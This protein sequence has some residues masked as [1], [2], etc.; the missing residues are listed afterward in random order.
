MSFYR[1]N[2]CDNMCTA[3]LGEDPDASKLFCPLTGKRNP[4]FR[5][6]DPANEDPCFGCGDHCPAHNCARKKDFEE[7]IRLGFTPGDDN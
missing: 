2:G 7:S 1:C 3:E 5:E 4:G 6:V